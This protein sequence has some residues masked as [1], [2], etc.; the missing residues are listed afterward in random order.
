MRP[1]T[2]TSSTLMLVSVEAIL[3]LERQKLI[4]DNERFSTED[5]KSVENV[6]Y[7]SWGNL[8]S[9]LCDSEKLKYKKEQRIGA[10]NKYIF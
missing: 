9:K 10:L 6:D 4:K 8:V 2:S 5:V 7:G 3:D 1:L